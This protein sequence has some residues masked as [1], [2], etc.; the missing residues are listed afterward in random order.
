MAHSDEPKQDVSKIETMGLNGIGTMLKGNH[1]EIIR[2][3]T[4]EEY[5]VAEKK[6]RRKL[7]FRLIAMVALIYVLNFLDR[8][9]QPSNG[10]DGIASM[11]TTI[12]EQHRGSQRR[13]HDEKPTPDRDAILNCRWAPLRRVHPNA[14]PVEHVPS[15]TSAID[16][17]S[18]MYG[19]LGHDQR[20]HQH[21]QKCWRTL[22]RPLLAGLC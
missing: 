21:R 8:V 7:D 17:H 6:L 22:R 19:S 1:E 10:L 9:R 2:S 14:S 11:L 5:K 4:D 12:S 3:M 20:L 18:G 13:R 16:L 15:T